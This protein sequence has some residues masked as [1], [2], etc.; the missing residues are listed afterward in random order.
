MIRIIVKRYAAYLTLVTLGV[1]MFLSGCGKKSNDFSDYGSNVEVADSN[2]GED[3]GSNEDDASAIDSEIITENVTANKSIGDSKSGM[4]SDKL[5]GKE[6]EYS[7]D[8]TIGGKPAD[9]NVKMQVDETD[10]LPIYKVTEITESDVHEDEIVASIFEGT[11]IALNSQNKEFLN[12]ENGDSSGIIYLI[13]GLCSYHSK[14]YG[15]SAGDS[16]QAWIDDDIFYLHTYEGV[17]NGIECQLIVGYSNKYHEKYVALY[18]KKLG[19]LAGDA[20]LDT[21]GFTDLDGQLFYIDEGEHIA[22]SID[23]KNVMN[24]RPNS[25]NMT[26]ENLYDT[27]LSVL[28]DKLYIDIPKESIDFVM[29]SDGSQLDAERKSEGALSELIFYRYDDLAD[30][31][32]PNAVRNGYMGIFNNEIG[33]QH[34]IPDVNYLNQQSNISWGCRFMV[35]NSGLVGFS[36]VTKYNFGE[37]IT[38]NSAIMNFEEGMNAFEKAMIE[39]VDST[40]LEIPASKIDFNSMHLAYC[41][42]PVSEGS[43][44]YY[45]VPVWVGDMIYNNNTAIIRGVINAVDGSYITVLYYKN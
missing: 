18:P 3:S 1:S 35:N 12:S 41:P 19:D 8:F 14:N 37:T 39:N 17:S 9:I 36:V 25:C 27:V 13:R 40:Q 10:T 21:M 7:K 24:D 2:G 32:F 15:N 20:S 43:E 42:I 38:D 6:L 34:I 31:N 23:I 11:G 5:G 28:H 44:E 26:K 45:M 33:N 4:L 16:I 29:S 30:S 22:K